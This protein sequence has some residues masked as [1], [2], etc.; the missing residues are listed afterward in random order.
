MFKKILVALDG[1]DT[2]EKVVT[3]L[4]TFLSK[5]EIKVIL[6]HIL[7]AINS[8][9]ELISDRPQPSRDTLYQSI[10]QQLRF[11]QQQIP[12]S[13][14]EISSGDAAEEIIRLA[15][16]HQADLIILGSRGLTGLKRIIEDSVSSFVV[17]ESPCSVL[18][19]KMS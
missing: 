13:Q 19:V 9:G 6:C 10:E 2:A 4:K 15:Y 18:V 16:I 7:P 17:A 12:D 1:G 14:I 11:Y 5:T 3:A 8:D